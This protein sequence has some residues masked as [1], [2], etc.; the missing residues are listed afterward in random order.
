MSNSS[1]KIDDIQSIIFGGFSS[2]FWIFRKHMISMDYDTMLFDSQEPGVK[3]SFPFFNWQCVTLVFSTRTVDLV[4]KNEHQMDQ[5]L[6][7]LVQQMQ[8]IDGKKGTA[9]FYIEAAVKY[10][11]EKREK[12]KNKKVLMIRKRLET[13]MEEDEEFD[14]TLDLQVLSEEEKQK[15]RLEKAAEI[16]RQTLFKYK[17]MRIRSKISYYSFKSRKTINELIIA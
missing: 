16:Y 5:L 10:E 13:L 15:I 4:I 7:Y 6:G 12:L 8:S 3:T 11:I 14:E 17:L 2:R 9:K 1:C